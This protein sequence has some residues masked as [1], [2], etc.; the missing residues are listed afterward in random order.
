MGMFWL[1]ALA[2]AALAEFV[3]FGAGVVR[4]DEDEY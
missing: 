1:F 3:P 4:N 2:C